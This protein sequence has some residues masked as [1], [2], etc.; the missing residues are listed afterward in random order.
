MLCMKNGQ[1]STFFVMKRYFYVFLCLVTFWDTASAARKDG[2]DLGVGIGYRK[3]QLSFSAGQTTPFFKENNHL[4]SVILDGYLDVYRAGFFWSNYLDGGGIVSG[5]SNS[6]CR[7]SIPGLPVFPGSF[8]QDVDGFFIDFKE[9]LGYQFDFIQ[10]NHGFRFI[11][12]VGYSVFY[13]NAKRDKSRPKD[14]SISG[15]GTISLDLSHNRLQRQW[16]GPLVGAD[17]MYQIQQAWILEGGYFYYFLKMKQKFFAREKITEESSQSQFLIRTNIRSDFKGLHGQS[18]YVK[19]KA[20]IAEEWR[21][22][23][24]FDWLFFTTHRKRSIEREKIHQVFP[25]KQWM[26]EKQYLSSQIKWNSFDAIFE[27]EYFY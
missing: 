4:Q 15:L 20:L 27:I 1:S 22:N 6:S 8:H 23:L 16:W 2:F 19:I 9:R 21:C 17:L 25:V 5:R 11:P 7:V 26:A 14:E 13:Q 18:F 10:C 24:K 12:E 3:D